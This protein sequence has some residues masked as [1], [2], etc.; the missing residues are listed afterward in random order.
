[1]QL[2]SLLL[3]TTA[4][5]DTDTRAM[6]H[7]PPTTTCH[8]LTLPTTTERIRRS[9]GSL[10]PHSWECHAL[11]LLST[12]AA[13]LTAHLADCL[14]A[15]T[16]ILYVAAELPTARLTPS[17]TSVVT[18]TA[19]SSSSLSTVDHTIFSLTSPILPADLPLRC[20]LGWQSLPSRD[21]VTHSCHICSRLTLPFV[22]PLHHSY[23]ML[24]TPPLLHNSLSH[25]LVLLCS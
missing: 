13:T 15:I 7:S 23:H 20:P 19:T 24:P 14:N 8:L 11:L 4:Y 10:L 5:T 22:C 12:A 18:T 9:A 25:H 2:H 17:S 6:T 3:Q 16:L 21:D 1:M